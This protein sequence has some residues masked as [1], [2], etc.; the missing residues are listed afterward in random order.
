MGSGIIWS[1]HLDMAL[2][3]EVSADPVMTQPSRNRNRAL[4]DEN[5]TRIAV[6]GEFWPTRGW[7]GFDSDDP[8]E[9][10]N[11]SGWL[12]QVDRIK[13]DSAPSRPNIGCRLVNTG[14]KKGEKTFYTYLSRSRCRHLPSPARLPSSLPFSLKT[15][16]ATATAVEVH[17]TLFPSLSLSRSLSHSRSL[18]SLSLLSCDSVTSISLAVFLPPLSLSF[19]ISL[20]LSQRETE[21]ESGKCLSHAHFPLISLCLS[22]S[23]SLSILISLTS[24]THSISLPFSLSVSPLSLLVLI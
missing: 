4:R 7:L 10:R 19:S 12:G 24:L 1:L 2:G 6:G 13:A 9:S 23:Q 15:A 11:D 21:R 22:H 18:L 14:Y 20:S 8:A 5:E 16:T 17:V 3:F